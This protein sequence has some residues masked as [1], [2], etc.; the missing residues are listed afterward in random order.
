MSV[1]PNTLEQDERPRQ[2]KAVTGK[3]LVDLA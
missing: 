2:I 1:V 3:D